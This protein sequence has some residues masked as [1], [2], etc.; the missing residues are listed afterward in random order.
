MLTHVSELKNQALRAISIAEYPDGITILVGLIDPS[1]AVL[2]LETGLDTY[3]PWITSRP[4]FVYEWLLHNRG[5]SRVRE[6]PPR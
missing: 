6:L 4:L 5:D 1:R 2:M 3:P